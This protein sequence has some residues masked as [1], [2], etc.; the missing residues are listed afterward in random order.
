[1][2][3]PIVARYLNVEIEG[4][5]HRLFFE[6]AGAGIPLLCLHTAG[7]DSRQ[8]RHLMTDAAITDRFRVIAFDLPWHGKSG[9]PDDWRDREYRLSTASYLAAIR[10]FV[11][12]LGLARVV[13]LGCSMSGRIVLELA[14][15]DTD[16]FRAVIGLQSSAAPT[17]RPGGLG[18]EWLHHPEVHGGELA[19]AWVSGLIAPMSPDDARWETLWAYGQS[20][21]GVFKGDLH[22]YGQD[23]DFTATLGEI[24][25]R[26]CPVY[27]LTG[28]YDYSVTPADTGA[29]AARI[30]GARF[31]PMPCLGHFPMSEHPARFREHLLPVL[32]EIVAR[33]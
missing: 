24:D 3:E 27:L 20:G 8:F 22:F 15:A 32:A 28:E 13:A 31:Q 11:A 14:R 23:G 18:L 25:T 12:A 21:P 10:A 33:G 29:T 9:A 5:R 6:E 7:S 2:L 26:R 17:S 4:E 19:I 16:R 30:E 1:M